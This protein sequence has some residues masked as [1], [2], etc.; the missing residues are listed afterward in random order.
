MVRDFIVVIDIY[1]VVFLMLWE[2]Y[3][4]INFLIFFYLGMWDFVYFFDLCLFQFIWVINL[5]LYDWIEYY[6]IE[7]FVIEI[8]QGMFFDGEK[9]DFWEGFIRCMK[10][11]RVLNVDLFLIFVDWISGI[12]G[13]NDEYLNFF[14]FVS[15]DFCY[16]QMIGK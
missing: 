9:V 7:W 13:Y 8:G 12:S 4:V 10:M 5:V 16:I 2:I 15:E 11:F 6:L 1:G 3:Q 14:E